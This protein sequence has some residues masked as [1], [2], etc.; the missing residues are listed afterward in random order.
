[1]FDADTAEIMFF[2]LM[3]WAFDTDSHSDTDLLGILQNREF[4]F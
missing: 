4:G 2:C 1:M 3:D